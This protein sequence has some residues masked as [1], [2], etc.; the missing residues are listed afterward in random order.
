MTIIFLSLIPFSGHD[1]KTNLTLFSLQ[2]YPK[3]CYELRMEGYDGAFGHLIESTVMTFSWNHDWEVNHEEKTV[4]L[5]RTTFEERRDAIDRLLLV[6][7]ENGTFRVLGKW[8]GERFPIFGPNRE[9]I[10]D[11][12]RSACGLFGIVTYGVQLITYQEDEDGLFIWAARRSP[13]K[14]LYPNRLGVT[15]GGSLPAGETPVECLIREAHEEAGLESELVKSHARSVGT[16]SYV[17]SSET[18]TTSDGESGLI[19]AEIQ[20]VYDMKVGK[21]VIPTSHDMEAS[22]ISLYSINEIKKALDDGEFTPAN[23]CLMLDF[24]IRHGL[25][26]FENEPRYN[27]IISRLHRPLGTR[28]A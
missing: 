28:T 13:K 26:T 10:A 3:D 23:A 11:L 22:N 7:R 14:T 8:T 21:D 5:L 2:S 18:K 4:R 16:I 17:T 6:E 25:V 19:R 9:L 27:E 15:V 20:Y 12:E 1:P 24:F